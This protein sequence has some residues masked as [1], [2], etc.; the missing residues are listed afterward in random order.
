MLVGNWCSGGLPK[1]LFQRKTS[2]CFSLG[3]DQILSP[4]YLP[5]LPQVQKLVILLQMPRPKLGA[6]QDI[7]GNICNISP[8]HR[9][10]SNSDL[11]GISDI[12]DR[13]CNFHSW[14]L[15][16]AFYT[17]TWTR[18]INIS[19]ASTWRSKDW[20][21]TITHTTNMTFLKKGEWAPEQQKDRHIY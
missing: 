1:K 11:Q 15:L 20:N 7:A 6:L 10:L 3:L 8:W 5:I 2:S 12:K 4:I 21:A 13:G 17:I 19:T 16:Y 18:I 14:S 9:R